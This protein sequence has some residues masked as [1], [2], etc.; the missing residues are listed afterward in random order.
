MHFTQHLLLDSSRS[1]AGKKAADLPQLV[2]LLLLFHNNFLQWLSVSQ[3]GEREQTSAN[4]S[5][6][7]L[8]CCCN[9]VSLVNV[10]TTIA[11]HVVNMPSKLHK[12][13]MILLDSD[14]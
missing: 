4:L 2:G 1:H 10:D 11:L 14:R 6:P 8:L 5:M 7:N 9:A 3:S 12:L 13:H